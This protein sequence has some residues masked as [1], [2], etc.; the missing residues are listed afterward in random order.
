[1]LKQGMK[2]RFTLPRNRKKRFNLLKENL[3]HTF[4]YTSFRSHTAESF[5]K[6]QD[7]MRDEECQIPESLYI[8]C[9]KKY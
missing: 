1:M 2:T 3:N 4:V 8:L 6:T 5:E 9:D 7:P